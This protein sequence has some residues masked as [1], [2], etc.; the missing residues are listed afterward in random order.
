MTPVAEDAIT[1]TTLLPSTCVPQPDLPVLFR[2]GNLAENGAPVLMPLPV[3][4]SLLLQPIGKSPAEEA[5]TQAL[6]LAENWALQLLLQAPATKFELFIYDT[7]LDTN[8]PTLERIAGASKA[9]GLPQRI[10]FISDA[11]SLHT[12]LENWQTDARQRKSHLLQS[13]HA[14]WRELL[15][16]EDGQPLRLV[17]FTHT[18]EMQ[19]FERTLAALPSLVQHG[20]RLGYWFW[21]VGQSTPPS[22]LRNAQ[23]RQQWQQWFDERIAADAL[24]FRVNA[25]GHVTFPKQWRGSPAID[26]Y[27]EFGATHADGLPD[28]ERTAAFDRYV[29]NHSQPAESPS[30]AEDFWRVRIGRFQGQDY[31]FRMGAKLGAFHAM[32][33]GTTGRGKSSFL[34][35][36]I[37]RTCEAYSP[38]EI[39]FY[40]IDL[41]GVGTFSLFADAPHREKLL[42]DAGDSAAALHLLRDVV[43]E[44]DR[45]KQQFSAIAPAGMVVNIAAHNRVARERGV[46]LMPYLVVVIDEVQKLFVE[47]D[48]TQ[49]REATKLIEEIAREGRAFGLTLCLASQTFL[50]VDL[51]RAAQNQFR[52]RLALRL[53]DTQDCNALLGGD[54]QN[55]APVMLPDHHMLVNDN[56]G[57]IPANRIVALDYLDEQAIYHRM[58]AVRERWPVRVSEIVLREESSSDERRDDEALL[59]PP[60]VLATTYQLGKYAQYR[61][62]PEP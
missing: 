59:P 34:K 47:G 30:A 49:R 60:A 22:T 11:G 3:G 32:V 28:A 33:G 43:A 42:S 15:K 31:Q 36:L 46:E 24:A 44:R 35:M 52:M 45:R 21:L 26:L 8:L 41:L 61:A 27:E 1:A 57:S 12:Q 20:P 10:H 40:L 56:G 50:G 5:M 13:G 48:F 39:R 14:D 19:D 55:T 16:H 2:I 9:R 6:A 38:E 23:Q 58:Q 7:S 4:Y 51:P 18:E 62:N 25:D 17:L 54:N 37:A 53:K 29:D